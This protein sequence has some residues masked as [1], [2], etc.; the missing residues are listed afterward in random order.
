MPVKPPKALVSRSS[1]KD[2]GYAVLQAQRDASLDVIGV[3]TTVAEGSAR[4]AVHGM[5]DILLTRQKD[6]R[7]EHAQDLRRRRRGQAPSTRL[8]VRPNN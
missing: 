3:L 7:P 6:R 8:R 5:R 4:V 2:A 1:G